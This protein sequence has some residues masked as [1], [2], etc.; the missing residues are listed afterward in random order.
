M[1]E[2]DFNQNNKKLGREMMYSAEDP[3]AIAKEQY[4]SRSWLTAI[5]RSL[6]KRLTYDII[7]QKKR[8]G[9]LCSNDAKSCYDWIV[10]LVASL[11]M[12]RVGAPVEPIICMLSVF[13]S[14]V[15]WCIVCGSDSSRGSRKWGRTSDLGSSEY[16]GV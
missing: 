9:V 8:P 13:R 3:R 6:N 11:A 2:A 14:G 5:D 4:G 7:R 1:Y 15:Q 12:Q 10:H 16:S